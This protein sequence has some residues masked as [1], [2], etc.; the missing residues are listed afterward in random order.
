MF[1]MKIPPH[2]AQSS[3]RK[4][5]DI[6]PLLFKTA[7]PSIDWRNIVGK[8]TLEICKNGKLLQKLTAIV[9]LIGLYTECA[10]TRALLSSLANDDKY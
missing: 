10:D 4:L 9:D 7:L 2:T 3:H 1:V 5:N 6:R 8:S